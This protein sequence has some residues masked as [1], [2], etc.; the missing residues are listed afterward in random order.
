MID[1]FFLSSGRIDAYEFEILDSASYSRTVG[2]LRGVNSGKLTFALDTDLKITGNLSISSDQYFDPCVI[3]IHYKPSL[4]GETK[5][6]VVATCFAFA[7]D[8]NIVMGRY[9]G[10]I[11]L[12]STLARYV[13][14]VLQ[15]D[16]TIAKG[17]SFKSEFS[18]FTTN[19][20]PGG[21]YAFDMNVKDVVV[22]EAIMIERGKKT[23]E[24][25]KA[26]ADGLG[27]SIMV[28]PYGTLRFIPYMAPSKK[29]RSAELPVGEYSVTLPGVKISN[30]FPDL[31]N[32]VAYHCQIQYRMEEYKL[33]DKGNKVPDGRGGYKTQYRTHSTYRIGKA[34]VDKTN[35]LHYGHRGR[36]ITKLYTYQKKLGD[37]KINET[38]RLQKDL[39]D[40]L[41]EATNKAAVALANVAAGVKLYTIECYYM[42][43]SI[44]D[45]VKFEYIDNGIRLIVD[46]IVQTI[47]MNIDVGSRCTVTLKHIRVVSN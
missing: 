31:P 45:V 39:A 18:R 24:V 25:V 6:I 7:K 35:H 38:Q 2:W 23:M 4:N 47:D 33:N 41:A 46:A 20:C 37:Y 9:T 5:D 16:F 22:P 12:K 14:D 21:K 15:G 26:V 29:K 44:G 34:Q 8:M 13:D 1:T 3:R 27:A 11:E 40:A 43:I 17:H 42:P 19:V 28:D 32:R 30:D 10:T 36:F